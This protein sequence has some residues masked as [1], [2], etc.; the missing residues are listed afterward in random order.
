MSGWAVA[1]IGLLTT[2][3]GSAGTYLVQG[4]LQ[5]GREPALI[6]K[7][8][9]EAHEQIY[10][11]YGELIEQQRRDVALGREE[12]R[13]ARSEAQEAR[14]RAAEAETRAAAAEARAAGAE[15][16]MR[17][18]QALVRQHVPDADGLLRDLERVLKS[19]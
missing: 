17:E 19:R 1:L 18:M 16:A 9:A 4:W 11:A 13:A 8:T 12:A 10:A 2:G 7:I 14:L 6:Q 5:R 3:I 15:A